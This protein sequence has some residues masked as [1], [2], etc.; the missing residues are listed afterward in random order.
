MRL[1][2][3]LALTTA[4]LFTVATQASAATNN[5]ASL[6]KSILQVGMTW[7]G[8]VQYATTDGGYKWSDKTSTLTLCTGWFVTAQAD[9]VTAG[10]CVDPAE[11]KTALIDQFLSDINRPDLVGQVESDWTVEGEAS[12]APIT[13]VVRVIQPNGVKGAV[14]K[15]A[16][17]AQVVDFLPVEQGDYT[18]LRVANVG[19]KTPALAVARTHPAVGTSLTAIGF[20]VR[21][22][23]NF[24]QARVRAS[25]KSGTASSQQVGTNGI[26][27]TEVNA[28]IS[29][30][31]SGGPTVDDRGGVLGVNSYLITSTA[32]NFNFITDTSGLRTFLTK[33]NVKFTTEANPTPKSNGGA[34]AI[35]LIVVLLFVLLAI[36]ALVIFAI[37]YSRRKDTPPLMVQQPTVLAP[38]VAVTAPSQPAG[39]MMAPTIASPLVT[40]PGPVLAPEAVYCQECG[41]SYPLGTRFCSK[42][43][44]HLPI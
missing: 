6:E 38:P 7:T 15:T 37:R 24:D 21:V 22:D 39:E 23:E 8:Y 9:I 25:F 30:G 29:P 44:T 32:Q 35:V 14:I 3:V 12:G 42:D 34:V 27:G 36:T 17:I 5:D 1:V 18:L 31:M 20:P 4:S 26:A 10:H 19:E 33:N 11:G 41:T 40:D 16:T 43:G 28:D 2:S 13:R